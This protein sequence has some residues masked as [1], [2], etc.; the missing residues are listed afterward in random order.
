[1]SKTKKIN[2]L[3]IYDVVI[4]L[5]SLISWMICLTSDSEEKI[6][7]WILPLAYTFVYTLFMMGRK[8]RKEIPIIVFNIVAFSR[9]NILP[10]SYYLFNGN[11]IHYDIKLEL[12]LM[13]I[14]LVCVFTTFSVF[15]P[16]FLKC[17]SENTD[18]K[19]ISYKEESI[20]GLSTLV[21]FILGIAVI[22][23]N[24]ILLKRIFNPFEGL[25]ISY[26]NNI[27]LMIYST[28]IIVTTLYLLIRIKKIKKIKE[29]YKLVISL[30]FIIFIV[31]SFASG[32]SGH[33]SR[34]GML[35][36]GIIILLIIKNLYK[37]YSKVISIS[38]ILL[39][40]I[41][42]VFGTANKFYTDSQVVSNQEI[43]MDLLEY[44]TLNAYLGGPYNISIAIKAKELFGNDMSIITFIN[45]IFGNCPGITGILDATNNFTPKYFNHAYYS[46][47]WIKDQI[48]PLVG[49]SYMYF[50]ILFFPILSIVASIGVLYFSKLTSKS[51][52]IFEYYAFMTIA[53]NTS[54]FMGVNLN[55]L[56]QYL[57]INALPLL[58]LSKLNYKL[59][60][61]YD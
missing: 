32:A 54:T 46:V 45:D 39:L 9:Y 16:K 40:M 13:V 8:Y 38:I 12:F 52:N 14:E 3:L 24:P 36:N 11:I 57:W 28:F 41:V 2:K 10:I 20:F 37:K 53:I 56:F 44:K 4:I 17:N 59:K 49:Q 19:F 42:L 15:A 51:K 22:A 31:P 21:V 58:I 18:V 30:V 6:Y 60:K 23:I 48:C 50:G 34:M 26:I 33:I 35:L 61:R 27:S 55:I 25:D 7:M 1:M 43:L 5:S 29:N 47:G